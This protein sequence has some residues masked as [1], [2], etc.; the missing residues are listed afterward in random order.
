MRQSVII[1]GYPFSYAQ[2]KTCSVSASPAPEPRAAGK[3]DAAARSIE[4]RGTRKSCGR[5]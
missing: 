4:S 1:V 5:L 2:W 3:V